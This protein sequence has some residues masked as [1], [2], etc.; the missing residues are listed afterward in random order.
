MDALFAGLKRCDIQL[1]IVAGIAIVRYV[2]LPPLGI[3]VVRG[4]I[5]YGIL[6]CDPL[7]QFALLIQ[8]AVPPAMNIGMSPH[9][10]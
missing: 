5:R 7:F 3:L 8:Y 4:A 6:K 2:L 10:F 9:N 1:K